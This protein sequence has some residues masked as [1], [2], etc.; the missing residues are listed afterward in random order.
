VAHQR[1]FGY[2]NAETLKDSDKSTGGGQCVDLIKKHVPEIGPTTGW[3]PGP[4]VSDLKTADI[5]KG[6]VIATFWNG[7]YPTDRSS[8]KHAAFYLEHD[9]K[10][11]RVVEQWSGATPKSAAKIRGGGVIKF[12]GIDTAEEQSGASPHMSNIGDYYYLVLD[13]R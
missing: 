3:K 11:I 12:K 7:K 4:R 8:G 10:G 1:Y 5:P 9:E 13:N 2:A 6:S